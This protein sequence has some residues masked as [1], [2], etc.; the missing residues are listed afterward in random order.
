MVW[1]IILSILVLV[2]FIIFILFSKDLNEIKSSINHSPEAG[3]EELIKALNVPT[4]DLNQ[5]I[6]IIKQLFYK[7]IVKIHKLINSGGDYDDDAQKQKF[8]KLVTKDS[9]KKLNQLKGN[10][11]I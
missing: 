8:Q 7:G 1:N 4:N 3:K 9:V 2:V 11:V 6:E 5:D 10:K